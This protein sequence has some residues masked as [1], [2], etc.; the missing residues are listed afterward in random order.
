MNQKS[1]LFKHCLLA[2]LA[3]AIA[4]SAT[5]LQ[6][7][8]DDEDGDEDEVNNVIMVTAAKRPQTLQQTPIAITVVSSD[9]IEETKIL[10]IFDLQAIVPTLRVTPLQRSTNTSFSLRGFANGTNNTGIEPSVGIFIDGV[11]R[12]RA[13]AQI[14]DLPRLDQIE[15]LS[16]PQS[17]LFGKNAS[18]GVINIRTMAPSR[19]FDAKIEVGFG[20][21]NQQLFKAYVT[22]SI[23]DNVA[24]SLSGLITTRDGYTESISGLSDLNDR[25]RWSIRGQLLFEPT[26]DVSFRFIIDKSEIDEICCTVANFVNGPTTPII[27]ALGGGVVLDDQDHFAYES[28]LN[29]DPV[30]KVDDSGFSLEAVVDFDSFTFTSI[31]AFRNNDS[32]AFFDA[33]FSS[34][35]IITD[36]NIVDIETITQEF[37]LT[38]S[39]E[40]KIDWMLGV[41]IFQED[42]VTS[43]RLEYDTAIRPFFDAL[44]AAAP[45]LLGA[46]EGV[47]GLAPGSFFSPDTF[48]TNSY[49]QSNDAYSVFATADYHISD[50]LTAT[51]G[52]A[53]TN[54]EKDITITTINNDVLSNI[55]LGNDLTVFNV[56]IGFIPALAPAIPTLLSLQFQQ[57]V[58]MLANSVEDGKSS[59]D[60]LTWSL[61]LAYEHNENINFFA[62]ASTGFKATSWNLSRDSLPFLEDQ[63][64]LAAANLSRGDQKFGTRFAGPEESTVYEIGMKTRFAKGAFNITLFDQTIEGFQSSIFDGIGFVLANAGQQST[65]GLE[66]DSVYRPND[67]WTFTLAG[68]LLDPTFDSFVGAS[69]VN[70]PEDFSGTK[71]SGVHEQSIVAGIKYNF[72]LSNGTYAYIRSDYI[73][74]SKVHTVGN[75]PESL[76]RE[77]STINAS[78]GLTFLNDVSLQFWVRNLNNDEYFYSAFPAPIQSGTFLAY[79]NQP[80]TFGATVSYRF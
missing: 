40:N 23:N 76:T 47:Y 73:Y 71:P 21:Y 61:R 4:F 70:G 12:S 17:T 14:G 66:F 72:E 33:D 36:S 45:G 32:N 63:T 38:S 58:L 60:D 15:V 43:D 13:A 9:T 2:S 59:D 5:A 29:H 18:A 53:Y 24:Y 11:Y 35:D 42:V 27:Q 56:P 75:V 62:T 80:R 30:N 69:G 46:V 52:V 49:T 1:R 77:V 57:P 34:A 22:N 50:Q 68:S 6:A 31:T 48:I 10:D 20:N 55:D 64:A 26:D 7:A 37:R 79:P 39:G 44:L 19:D 3:A 25:D 74:E 65:K 67:S 78:A 16:G 41:F 51:L 54:D 8:E 28:S